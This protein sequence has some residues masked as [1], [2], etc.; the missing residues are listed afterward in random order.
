MFIKLLFTYFFNLDIDECQNENTDCQNFAHCINSQGSYNCEC[1][2]GYKLEGQ[3]CIGKLYANIH[4]V[5]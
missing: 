5:V 4:S 1:N 2:D 3:S